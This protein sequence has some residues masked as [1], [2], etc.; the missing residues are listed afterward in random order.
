M[1]NLT[2]ADSGW[3]QVESNDGAQE[4]GHTVTVIW[5]VLRSGAVFQHVRKVSADLRRKHQRG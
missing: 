4:Q 3:Y 1:T 2:K 5:E